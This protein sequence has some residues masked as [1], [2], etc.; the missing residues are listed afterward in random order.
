MNSLECCT[1]NAEGGVGVGVNPSVISDRIDLFVGSNPAYPSGLFR[2]F[3][4]L[5]AVKIYRFRLSTREFTFY[6]V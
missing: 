3:D 4:L 5:S 2:L 6:V 1:E